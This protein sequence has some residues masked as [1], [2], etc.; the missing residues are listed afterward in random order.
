MGHPS[1]L[2]SAF[3]KPV[4][5][6][7]RLYLKF[8]TLRLYDRFLGVW[9]AKGNHDVDIDCVYGGTTSGTFRSASGGFISPKTGKIAHNYIV[10]TATDDGARKFSF[11]VSPLFGAGT[12]TTSGKPWRL[13]YVGTQLDLSC[14]FYDSLDDI[15]DEVKEVFVHLGINSMFVDEL[16]VEPSVIESAERHFRYHESKERRVSELINSIRVL[17]GSSSDSSGNLRWDYRGGKV[18]YEHVKFNRWDDTGLPI[19]YAQA[20]KTYRMKYFESLDPKDPL[21]SPKL[22]A[23]LASA[24]GEERPS[25]SDWDVVIKELDTILQNTARWLGISYVYDGY[26]VEKK[27][28]PDLQ[29]IDYPFADVLSGDEHLLNASSDKF[30]AR[31]WDF[32]QVLANGYTAPRHIADAIGL[33]LRSVYNYLEYFKA[34]GL[35]HLRKGN[36]SFVSEYI[37]DRFRESFAGLRPIRGLLSDSAMDNVED[38]R[39]SISENNPLW[40]L[41]KYDATRS[42]DFLARIN[43]PNPQDLLDLEEVRRDHNRYVNQ[44]GLNYPVEYNYAQKHDKGRMKIYS[45]NHSNQYLRFTKIPKQ[46]DEVPVEYATSKTE[47]AAIWKQAKKAGVFTKV[48]IVDKILS[49]GQD[50]ET[51]FKVDRTSEAYQKH[52]KECRK[53]GIYSL[54]K[55]LSLF[56]N[57]A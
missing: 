38:R 22:E 54:S 13:D 14:S 37:R 45:Q 52:L 53:K 50:V 51:H 2:A 26:F 21:Y 56:N 18:Y 48:H 16:D 17:G 31:H 19:R 10:K 4:T 44:W 35:I 40:F 23:Y 32:L 8:P 39:V 3:Q 9:L 41:E 12:K 55:T 5:H 36:V 30:T 27:Y 20:L 6:K 42:H 15:L 46:T 43:V 7:V 24:Y 28:S 34:T 49:N 25:L 47:R 29:L 57:V 11:V 1:S 33:S